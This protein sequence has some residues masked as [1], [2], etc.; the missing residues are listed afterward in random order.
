MSSPE[1][2]EYWSRI[3]QARTLFNSPYHTCKPRQRASIL[4]RITLHYTTCSE[5]NCTCG[6]QQHF[7]DV[8]LT[9]QTTA[10]GGS[11]ST[12]RRPRRKSQK[13]KAMTGGHHQTSSVPIPN[14]TN[15]YY[16]QRLLVKS[17]DELP[18]AGLG[19]Y[20]TAPIT[21]GEIIGIYENYS[22]GPRAAPQRI[23]HHTNTSHYAVKHGHLVRDAWDPIQ[24]RPCCNTAYANDSMDSSKDNAT[25]SVH[26]LY[27]DKLLM[28]ATTDIAG[29]ESA[30]GP[31]YL[32][33]G[34]YY[35]CDDRYPLAVQAQAVR[36]YN[37]D[38]RRST[39]ATDGLWRN[40]R[41]FAALCEMFPDPLQEEPVQPTTS[42]RT[43]HP[44]LSGKKPANKRKRKTPVPIP[45]DSRQRTLQAFVMSSREGL[46]ARIDSPSSVLLG[47]RLP[48]HENTVSCLDDSVAF[49]T[50]PLNPELLPLAISTHPNMGSFIIDVDSHTRSNSHSQED[51]STNQGSIAPDPCR[52]VS[53]NLS[54][55]PME[56][57]KRFVFI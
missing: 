33:Y 53:A 40:L 32:P 37:I 16:D 22:G 4:A 21:K 49:T 11:A 55:S 39:E 25:F 19:L 44:T 10:K 38:I 12:S 34:G 54:H 2:R 46:A 5:S 47:T 6:L 45:K 56:Y 3:P 7:D 35:W 51:N 43:P 27:P 28:I 23:L 24:Q 20:T 17:A 15:H 52:T 48:C 57:D 9:I 26:T 50:T 13:Q 30:P 42:S 1:D 18:G 8:T 14:S 31:I 29:S 36:R 41:N